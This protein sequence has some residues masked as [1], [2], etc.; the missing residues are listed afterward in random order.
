VPVE[1]LVG[2]V[3]AI[4]GSWDPIVRHGSGMDLA[5]GPAFLAVLLPGELTLLSLA[6]LA[7]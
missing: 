4:L 3:D 2:R 6:A 7:V 5:H 1:N